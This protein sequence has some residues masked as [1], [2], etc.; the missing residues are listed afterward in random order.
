MCSIT[1]HIAQQHSTQSHQQP[2]PPST[3]HIKHHPSIHPSPP[4][5]HPSRP[6]ANT[7]PYIPPVRTQLSTTMLYFYQQRIVDCDCAASVRLFLTAT[8]ATAQRHKSPSSYTR[9][10]AI[11]Q[12]IKKQQSALTPADL[13]PDHLPPS[14]PTTRVS[15]LLIT[16]WRSL[17]TPPPLSCEMYI[18]SGW[19]VLASDG[20]GG[21][22]V[23]CCIGETWASSST[24]TSTSR[25]QHARVRSSS[26]APHNTVTVA[27]FVLDYYLHLYMRH[28]YYIYM[29]MCGGAAHSTAEMIR[30]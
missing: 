13:P 25:M 10:Q 19:S 3:F 22:S 5:V 16:R 26:H 2:H 20:D 9:T 27:A 7:I 17:P 30:S 11:D 14:P 1:H 6:Q 4:P 12:S 29:C 18:C 28:I 15:L 21:V 8:T 24:S 23:W